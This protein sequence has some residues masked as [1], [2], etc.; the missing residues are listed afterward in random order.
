MTFVLPINMLL[1]LSIAGFPML[2][3]LVVPLTMPNMLVVAAPPPPPRQRPTP[4]YRGRRQIVGIDLDQA[5]Q[6]T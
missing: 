5:L 4:R 6:P 1:I 2:I 3:M